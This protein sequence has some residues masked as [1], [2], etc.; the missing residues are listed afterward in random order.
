MIA[1]NREIKRPMFGEE[2]GR[3]GKCERGYSCPKLEVTFSLVTH[4]RP[5]GS[6]RPPH[7]PPE[8]LGC[9][10]L[11]PTATPGSSVSPAEPDVF[12]THDAPSLRPP[13]LHELLRPL[14]THYPG[15]IRCPTLEHSYSD[16]WILHIPLI[17]HGIVLLYKSV[18]VI[19]LPYKLLKCKNYINTCIVIS[20]YIEH[21]NCI[22]NMK[23]HI[24]VCVWM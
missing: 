23:E 10:P 14:G 17:S 9:C 13:R 1:A 21:I 11:L 5:A 2:C 3:T 16:F 20:M 22:Y 12:C 6:V 19:L 15:A 8:Q 18:H 4:C 7:R 24:Y